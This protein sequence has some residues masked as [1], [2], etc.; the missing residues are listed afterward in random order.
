MTPTEPHP[1]EAPRILLVEDD[2]G[3]ALLV[4]VLLEEA[5][6]DGV[7]IDRARDV[8]EAVAHLDA[9]RPGSTWCALVDLGL[10]D[11][12]GLD[13]LQAVRRAA[14]RDPVV[15]L[16]GLADDAKGLA[17]VAAG[18]QDYLVKGKVQAEDLRRAVRYAVERCRADEAARLL[19][20]E[21]YL[22][23]EN[24]RLERGLL[25]K[26]L[27]EQHHGLR[28]AS[29]YRP[30]S[31]RLRIGGDFYD[32]V[33]YDGVV[34]VVVG[35]V[36]GHGPD[37]AAIGVVL[38]VA[39]RALVRAGLPPEEV[40]G[41]LNDLMAVEALEL[42]QFTTVASFRLLGEGRVGMVLAGHPG[43]F[44]ISDHDVSVVDS[45]AGPPLGLWEGL[46]WAEQIHQFP[47]SSIVLAYTDG[48]VEGRAE[49]GSVERLGLEGASDLVRHLVAEAAGARR[50]LDERALDAL[51]TAIEE[52]HGGA[53]DDDVAVI[54]VELPG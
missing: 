13:A 25:P 6:P 42:G 16:T 32:V 41:H 7:E 9:H 30:G 49:P 26:P 36:C 37:E 46:H 28:W 2:D 19:L 47:A 10:P 43:P 44:V 38:R 29:R 20:E 22:H 23:E 3:D 39:W 12:E 11:A 5:F 8:A 33:E 54:A 17:A 15:V 48:L 1:L 51:L 4:E 45:D 34:H 40:M 14:P 53:L 18:A 50:A 27:L 35:D 21:H 24:V 31:N 52:R